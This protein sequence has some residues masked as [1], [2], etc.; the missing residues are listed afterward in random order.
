MAANDVPLFWFLN[1]DLLYMAVIVAI[2]IL[3]W[4]SFSFFKEDREI[5]KS[6][7]RG[8]NLEVIEAIRLVPN[9]FSGVIDCDQMVK[10]LLWVSDLRFIPTSRLTDIHTA[11]R[12]CKSYNQQWFEKVEIELK[13]RNS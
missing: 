12:N 1:S 9:V 4:K 11:C 8:D 6:G 2:G 7:Y 13:R 5:R 3:L 10:D